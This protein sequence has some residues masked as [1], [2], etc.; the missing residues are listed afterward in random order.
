VFASLK[1]AFPIVGLRPGVFNRLRP[2]KVD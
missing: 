1:S 2:Y